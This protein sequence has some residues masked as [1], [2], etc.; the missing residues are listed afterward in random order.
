[1]KIIDFETKGNLVRFYLGEDNC[2]DYWG[3]DWD[4]APYEHNAGK[5]YDKYI[6][7]YID[8]VFPFDWAVLEPKDDWTYQYNSPYSKEDFKSRKA[9]CII[10]LPPEAY[11]Y[12]WDCAYSK[13]LGNDKAVKFYF[14]D[15]L[16]KLDTEV[17]YRADNKYIP[18]VQKFG[19]I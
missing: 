9:P 19:L 4:D 13:E 3:D 11:E 8:V 2:Q 5:V 7:S 12:D 6:S 17:I 16:E 10:A 18:I 14:G 1:M 15:T